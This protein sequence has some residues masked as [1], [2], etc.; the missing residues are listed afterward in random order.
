M[1]PAPVP[2][3]VL[4]CS[5]CHK[6]QRD[7]IKLVTGPEVNICNECTAI[8]ASLVAEDTQ[9]VL[10]KALEN[11]DALECRLCHETKPSVQLAHV[12]NR[13]PVC[14]TCVATIKVAVGR[15]WEFRQE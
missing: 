4:R 11:G 9:A 8:C 3:T 14:F 1:F 2:A 5:F 6:T 10:Q 15:D 12:P 13:G 7:V